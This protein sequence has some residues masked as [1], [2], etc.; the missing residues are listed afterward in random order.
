MVDSTGSDRGKPEINPDH[1]DEQAVLGALMWAHTNPDPVIEALTS[2]H[3]HSPQHSLIYAHLTAAYAA[4]QPTDPIAIAGRLRDSGDLARVGGL[5]YLHTLYRVG[6]SATD[7]R[8]NAARIIAAADARATVVLG[9]RISQLGQENLDPTRR[10]ELLDAAIA[11]HLNGHATSNGHHDHPI[12]WGDLLSQEP[13]P[14]NWIAGKLLCR[15]QQVALVGDGKAGKSLLAHEWAFRA[16]AGL[17]F[18]GDVA[19]APLRVL[20]LDQENSLDEIR[21]RMRS[22]GARA[23]QLEL[24]DYRSFP[25]LAPLNTIAGAAAF[26]RLVDAHEPDLIFLDT[27]SRMVEGEENPADTWLALYRHSLVPLKAAGR[28]CVRLDHF[29]KDTTR[30]A[31]G[32]SAKTQDVDHVWELAA[33]LDGLLQLTRS[34]TRTGIGADAYTLRRV[35]S[36]EPGGW[37]YGA[38]RHV[39]ADQQDP[40]S[41]AIHRLAAALDNAGVPADAGRHVVRT[42]CTELGLKVSNDLIGHVIR[43][44]RVMSQM[45]DVSDEP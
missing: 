38:T 18:L 34:H 32:S 20:Y 33:G 14:P 11:N 23:D 39:L 31:R 30:G 43:Y 44:R 45:G 13:Q 15:G 3:F 40:Q 16:A 24:V 2:G 12:N 42:A 25:N 28:A 37:A 22:F 21:D 26:L 17:P 29:G 1:L 8:W 5:A 4:G 27:I 9:T 10:R 7:P 41:V 36:R 19:R 35:G 6:G